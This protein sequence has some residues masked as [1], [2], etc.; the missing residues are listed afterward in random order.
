MGERSQKFQRRT[1]L[2]KRHLQLKYGL[3]VFAAM[4]FATLIVGGDLYWT[5]LRFLSDAAPDKVPLLHE[6]M[7]MNG[8]KMVLFVG[9]MLIVT[10]FVSHRWA[11]P[12]YRFER[13]A[14][15]LAGGDLTH[16][17][18]LRTGDDLMELQD[19]MNAMIASLQR[20]VQKDRALAE[21]L[22][23]RLEETARKLP[24][25]AGPE[26]VA[27]LKDDLRAL[28]AEL[29]HITGGFKV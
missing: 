19:E 6:V 13:S 12:I 18:S 23:T 17:V 25:S 11:G 4:F 14:Q 20:K 7:Q 9:V 2:I 3:V 27:R 15:T 8:V 21:H 22:A 26:D 16:R 28:K 5:I 1:V 10:L 24:D 29:Q